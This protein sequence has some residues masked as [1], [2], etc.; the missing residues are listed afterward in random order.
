MSERDGGV[1]ALAGEQQRQWEPDEG[2]APDDNGPL[3]ARGDV[4]ALE[5][6]HHAERC[7][8]HEAG[9][10]THES[11][12]RALGQ[13]VDVLLR[14]DEV[15]DRFGVETVGERELHE[16]AV[17]RVVGDEFTHDRL[18]LCLGGRRRQV[19]MA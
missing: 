19:D 12:H 9:A 7:A 17:H 15:D 4:V 8:A 18:D 1:D 13:A 2:R 6:A 16:D 3:A 10:T 11:A 5:Q 14:R